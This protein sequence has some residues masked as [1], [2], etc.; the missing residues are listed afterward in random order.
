MSQI[1]T[2]VLD[3]S[4]GKPAVNV[5]VVL[6]RQIAPGQW[7]KRA[8]GATDADGRLKN[9]LAEGAALEAGTY[10]LTFETSVYFAA[11]GGRAFYPQVMVIF[12]VANPQEHYHIPLLLSPYG[13]ST[14][15]G[16]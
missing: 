11:R 3:T 14:Y 1:T 6:E 13:Y 8:Q 10:R 5:S 12:E 9:L 4:L 7:K 15:R 2:H 16:S